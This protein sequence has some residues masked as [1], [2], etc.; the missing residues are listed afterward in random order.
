MASP[1][2]VVMFNLER[3]FAVLANNDIIPIVNLLDREG[4]PCGLAE[5]VMFVAKLPD[6]FIVVNISAYEK[7]TIN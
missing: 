4:D 1:V 3:G 5:A 7:V 2:E 6:E